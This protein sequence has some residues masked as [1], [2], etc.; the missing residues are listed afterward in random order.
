[1][2]GGA[3][4]FAGELIDGANVNEL[5]GLAAVDDGEDFFLVGAQGFVGAGNVIRGWRDVRGIFGYRALFFEPFLAAAV[6]EADVLVAVELQLPQC[7]GGEPVV[8][9]TVEEDGGVVG[10]AGGAEKF[11][12]G[13]FVDEVAAMPSWSWVCQFQPTAPGMWP[14]S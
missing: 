5:A 8:V 13:G 6:D 1:M 7:V 3:I 9:V 4:D 10:N 14:W 12:E 11:L 2:P